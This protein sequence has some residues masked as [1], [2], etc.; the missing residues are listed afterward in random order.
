MSE[1]AE[2]IT[3]K[4]SF[5]R[6]LSALKTAET[7]IGAL[8]TLADTNRAWYAMLKEYEHDQRPFIEAARRLGLVS[9]IEVEVKRHQR[10]TVKTKRQHG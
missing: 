7:E 2:P 3:E 1:V 9:E 8:V 4:P 5:E 6:L 10:S